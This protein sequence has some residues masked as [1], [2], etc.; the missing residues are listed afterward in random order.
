MRKEILSLVIVTILMALTISGCLNE[1]KVPTAD[2]S[3]STT[4]IGTRFDDNST[5]EGGKI[6]EWHWDFGDDTTS[7]EKDPV[8][9]YAQGGDY[10]V[11][12][13]V[14]DN[15]GL[16]DSVTKK[17]VVF[18]YA[19]L[20]PIANFTHAPMEDITNQTIITFNASASETYSRSV[21]YHWDFG[22]GM[23]LTVTNTTTIHQFASVGV[24]TVNLTITDELGLSGYMTTDITVI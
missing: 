24:Y 20:S 7:D 6:K 21:T 9:L 13:T 3:Y 17:V 8:H 11:T 23:A 1:N 22:D 14:T 16:I 4:A 5:D 2:F 12:L 15:K 10:N 18:E 19:P